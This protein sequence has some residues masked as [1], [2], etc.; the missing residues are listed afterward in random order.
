[1]KHHCFGFI[2][3]AIL[4]SVLSSA[5]QSGG[6]EPAPTPGA[7]QSDTGKPARVQIAQ[8]VSTGLLVK[9]V[10]PRYPQ[11]A[12]QAGIQGS[13]ILQAEIDKNGRVQKLALISGHPMLA[14]AAI[15]A[16][17]RW[18]YKPYLLDAQPVNVETQIIVNFQL[19]GR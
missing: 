1:M 14:P 16:V 17:K 18:K 10:T 12:R 11:D 19:L 13:V 7:P 15:K 5:Q 3:A 6:E 4:T 2:A 9:R 8:G